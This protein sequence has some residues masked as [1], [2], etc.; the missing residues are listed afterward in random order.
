MMELDYPEGA[1]PLDRSES[2]GLKLSHIAT[3]DQLNQWEQEN[4]L[5]AQTKYFS[6]K[7]RD[8]LSEGFLLRLHKS[9]FGNVWKWAGKY[10]TSE[11]NIGAPHWDVSV[12]LRGLCEDTKLWVASAADP[13][14]EIAARFHHRLVSIHPFA[15]GNGRHARMA[16]DL[17]LTHVLEQPRFTWGQSDLLDSGDTRRL[18]LE[19]L[20]AADRRDYS[21]LF[22]FVRT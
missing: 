18:Y 1:T 15:N 16:A 4:I 19:A 17:L 20:R 14:D 21:L 22:R 3:R 2:E 9:M 11:K 10:R 13:A 5:Q 12:K 6:R 8:I 7:H